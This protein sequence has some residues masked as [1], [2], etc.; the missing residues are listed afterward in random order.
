MAVMFKSLFTKVKPHF[1]GA[2]FTKALKL[3]LRL[4]LKTLVLNFVNRMV[5]P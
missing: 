1:P 4:K 3:K 5:S 2:D